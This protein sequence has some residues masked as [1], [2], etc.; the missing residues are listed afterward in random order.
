MTKQ[1]QFCPHC[2]N[3]NLWYFLVENFF[4]SILPTHL[5]GVF[6]PKAKFEQSCCSCTTMKGSCFKIQ[7]LNSV[8]S[9]GKVELICIQT[10]ATSFDFIKAILFLSKIFLVVLFFC[11]LCGKCALKQF[12]RLIKANQP[13]NFSIA[14]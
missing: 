7:D 13:A 4:T 11:C 12:F 6:V 9:R 3:F 1:Y 14:W 5:P 8:Y 10:N 2:L